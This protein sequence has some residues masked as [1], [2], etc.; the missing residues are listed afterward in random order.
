MFG[1]DAIPIW[2][3]NLPSPNFPS[4]KWMSY[5]LFFSLPPLGF[6]WRS[7]DILVDVCVVYHSE[8]LKVTLSAI[9]PICY[10]ASHADIPVWLQS[11]PQVSGHL[12][13][14]LLNINPLRPRQHGH[15]L[16]DNI[17]QRIF[18]TENISI[19]ITTALKFVPKCPINSIQP[20]V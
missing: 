8:L 10:G 11:C 16:P 4:L 5:N 12:F 1:I 15:H 17:F 7:A 13:G 3:L 2:K 19:S 20:L 18:L 6:N 14:T 9:L